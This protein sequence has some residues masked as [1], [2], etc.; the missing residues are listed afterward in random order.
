MNLPASSPLFY[1]ST[2]RS[3]QNFQILFV[4]IANSKFPLPKYTSYFKVDGKY[5]FNR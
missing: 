5:I 2:V 1:P 4:Y 3:C